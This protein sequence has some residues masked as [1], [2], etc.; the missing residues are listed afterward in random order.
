MSHANPPRRHAT[1]LVASAI[2]L[3]LAGASALGQ[4]DKP[5]PAVE[6]KTHGADLASTR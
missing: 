3:V 1:G 5:A 2:A 4:G 6:W